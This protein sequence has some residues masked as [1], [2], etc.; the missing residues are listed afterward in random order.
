M[1]NAGGGDGCNGG[2]GSSTGCGGVGVEEA[3]A[4][5]GGWTLGRG[6]GVGGGGGGG[7]GGVGGGGGGAV[8]MLAEMAAGGT[9]VTMAAEVGVE[10]V[11][12]AT[13][14]H[15][16][17]RACPHNAA[18]RACHSSGIEGGYGTLATKHAT[19]FEGLRV[20]RGEGSTPG[21]HPLKGSS[22]LRVWGYNCT[23]S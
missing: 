19:A 9:A 20:R 23:P 15:V 5:R 4:G 10:E 2:G 14:A 16:T 21:P 11:T 22:A 13:T 8:G 6:L 12:T 3:R 18:K 1:I 7:D 17:C